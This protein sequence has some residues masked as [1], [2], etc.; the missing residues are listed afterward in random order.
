MG[1]SWYGGCPQ[2]FWEIKLPL[3]L[4]NLTQKLDFGVCGLGEE[5][6]RF[7]KKKKGKEKTKTQ[8]KKKLIA[9]KSELV[10][11]IWYK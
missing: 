1:E 6:T 10:G 3:Q 11:V 7:R 4:N 8:K 5:R 2:K 9:A